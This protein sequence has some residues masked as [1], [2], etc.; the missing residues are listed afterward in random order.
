MRRAVLVSTFG[1]WT[2]AAQL[3][4]QEGVYYGSVAGRVTDLQGAPVAGADVTARQLQ[5]NVKTAAVSDPDGRFR[6][7]FLRI[8]AY[9]LTV[10]KPGFKA[11]SRSLAIGAGAAYQI[12]IALGLGI[13]ESVTVTGE[14][15]VL[16]TARS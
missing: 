12:P 10:G 16:E 8:G 13:E 1:L 3:P 5:T 9:E 6:F 2:A 14:A 11:A 4:A 7:A 15:V